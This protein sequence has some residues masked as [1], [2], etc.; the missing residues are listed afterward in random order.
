[1]GKKEKGGG[2][3]RSDSVLVYELTSSDGNAGRGKKGRGEGRGEEEKG[4]MPCIR[5]DKIHPAKE[6]LCIVRSNEKGGRGGGG[7]G[8]KKGRGRRNHRCYV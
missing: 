2:K 3:R 1:M 8:E 4:I 5:L 6:S 7:R